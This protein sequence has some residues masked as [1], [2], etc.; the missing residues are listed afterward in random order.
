[1][2]HGSLSYGPFIEFDVLVTL[3]LEF[4]ALK[5]ITKLVVLPTSTK[6]RGIEIARG[7][8]Q[9]NLFTETAETKIF[10]IALCSKDEHEVQVRGHHLMICHDLGKA[11]AG[12]L[13]LITRMLTIK[14]SDCVRLGQSNVSQA[15]V[16]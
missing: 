10:G 2:I 13:Q 8:L 12:Y 14:I 1:M 4:Y 15:Y 9:P 16:H 7:C 5:V 3:A 11:T 6:S